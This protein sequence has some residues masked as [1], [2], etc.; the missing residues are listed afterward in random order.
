MAA[1]LWS[2]RESLSAMHGMPY[3]TSLCA[4][5]ATK[6]TRQRGKEGEEQLFASFAVL[7]TRLV[8]VFFVKL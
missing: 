5:W 6:D 4:I 2:V 3:I 7:K 8:F 1:T